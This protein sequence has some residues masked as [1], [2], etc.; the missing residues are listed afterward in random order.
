[1]STILLF[2][3]T[4]AQGNTIANRLLERG[5]RILAPVRSKTSKIVLEERNITAFLT[6]FSTDSL[7]P[8]IEQVD[9][10]VLQIPATV[11]PKTMLNIAQNAIAAIE[12][13]EHPKVIFVISSTIP[14]H[15]TGYPSVDVRLEMVRMAL[16]KLPNTPILSATEYL[17]NFSTA[18]RDTILK[19][20]IIPQ[21]IPADY[22]VNYLSWEDL[23]TY[24]AA[25]LDTDVLLGKVYPIGGNEGITGKDLAQRLSAV[26]GKPLTYTPISHNALKNF[27]TPI[28]GVEIAKDY[29]AFYAWQDT[30]GAAMLNPDTTNIRKLLHVELPSFEQWAMTSFS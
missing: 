13:A 19:D 4:G 15:Y 6:D 1:M 7:L 28:L 5:D 12:Q 14:A 20:G 30:E 25:A 23:A 8:L 10:V 18:Y 24:V 9:Q 21:T 17:E 26:I 2:N 11:A 29:A 22:P 3:A 27:L 16:E